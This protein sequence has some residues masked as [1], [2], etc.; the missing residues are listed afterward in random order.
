MSGK[1]SATYNNKGY[2]TPNGGNATNN[3]WDETIGSFDDLDIPESLL[4]GIYAHGF[5]TPTAI[6]RRGISAMLTGRD[7]IA[8]AQSGTGKTGTFVIGSLGRINPDL[9]ECQVLILAPTRELAEQTNRSVESLAHYMN[10]TSY[11]C[12]GGKSVRN[13][14]RILH[15]GAHVVSGTPGRIYDMIQRG[16]LRV[17]KLDRFILDE[18][19]EVL[20]GLFKEQVYRIFQFV[21][22]SVQVCLFSATLPLDVLDMT[23]SFMRDPIR[24]LVKK[25]ELTLDGIK[26]FY[27][28]LER[29][30]WKL[31]CLFD[32]YETIAITQS[33]IFCNTRRNAE[34]LENE[35]EERD[36]TVSCIHG[37]LE[38][39][40][41]DVI[42]KNFRS[43]SSRVLIATDVLARGIDVQQV[44][45]V[46]NFSLP[47]NRENYIHRIGR[48]GRHGR[49]GVAINFV[50]ERDTRQ[51]RE[52]EHFYKTKIPEMPHNIAALI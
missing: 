26:H 24:I 22:E 32:L 50:T 1:E 52:I 41:R 37:D 36:F 15:Q 2:S 19:D 43:G 27:V 31:G 13:D 23:E 40:E 11:S 51:L 46:L 49:K 7:L 30:E 42:M 28:A 45:L 34:W 25:A 18:A 12:I 33:I 44:S 38:Q 9:Y 35:M 20:S 17:D 47:L 21:P 39:K 8:Q 48:A 6:Q 16:A 5:E 3:E 14:L 10:I 29:E 4:R